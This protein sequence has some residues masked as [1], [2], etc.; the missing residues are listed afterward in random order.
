M[1][2]STCCNC[3]GPLKKN[4]WYDGT[5]GQMSEVYC[6]SCDDD[7]EENMVKIPLD[8]LDSP[9][10]LANVTR[11]RRDKRSNE[12]VKHSILTIESKLEISHMSRQSP[13]IEQSNDET[14]C[15]NI[16]KK[17]MN[18]NGQLSEDYELGDDATICNNQEPKS[19]Q[20]KIITA[21]SCKKGEKEH[22]IRVHGKEELP[23]S[24]E[25]Q[26]HHN[27][28]S[29]K[30]TVKSN[31]DPN[32][33]ISNKEKLPVHKNE[34]NSGT[35]TK[36]ILHKVNCSSDHPLLVS[37]NSDN[38]CNGN[39]SSNTRRKVTALPQSQQRYSTL[40]K[41]KKSTSLSQKAMPEV[42]HFTRKIPTRITPDGTSIY[43][44]CDLSKE[45]KKGVVMEP[46]I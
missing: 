16:P 31:Y 45:T 27:V 26:S 18:N 35:K 37:S 28:I 41:T 12:K 1:A 40:P 42:G 2:S 24:P 3:F 15:D 21:S 25:E 36:H 34:I 44:W 19:E 14:N 11:S 43:Y 13:L 22:M 4:Q 20:Y 17:V 23:V 9:A 10:I 5:S 30:V 29:A 46:F 39:D 38:D 32:P 8:R 33:S 6:R 7:E